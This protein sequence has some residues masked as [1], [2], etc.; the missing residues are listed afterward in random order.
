MG[1]KITYLQVN[2]VL[3]ENTELRTSR[4]NDWRGTYIPLFGY[5]SVSRYPHMYWYGM[6]V[7]V[8]LLVRLLSATEQTVLLTEITWDS[9]ISNHSHDFPIMTSSNGNISTLLSLCAENPPVTG[10]PFDVAVMRK[11]YLQHPYPNFQCSLAEH[12]ENM[13]D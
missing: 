10:R 4:I 3:S 12:P 6:V 5:F 8:L 13:D 9:W 2:S 11:V 1:L 7:V